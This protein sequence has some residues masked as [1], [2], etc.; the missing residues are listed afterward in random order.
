MHK[1]SF[2]ILNFELNIFVY[3]HVPIGIREYKI[4]SLALYHEKRIHPSFI[5]ISSVSIILY[6][7]VFVRTAAWKPKKNLFKERSKLYFDLCWS[8]SEITNHP[9]GVSS[10]ISV[11]VSYSSKGFMD[12]KVF[13]SSHYSMKIQNFSFHKKVE[14]ELKLVLGFSAYVLIISS[15]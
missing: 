7:N 14:I 2:L 13:K 3:L 10:S 4:M 15:I 5:S 6:R 1:S 12:G 9:I 8:A 11:L